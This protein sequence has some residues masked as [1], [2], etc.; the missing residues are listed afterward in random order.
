MARHAIGV[1]C[2]M[3]ATEIYLFVGI[4]WFESLMVGR[5]VHAGG[6]T[7]LVLSFM[8]G[9]GGWV[10][11]AMRRPGPHLWER[12]WPY[13]IISIISL[14]L[15]TVTLGQY[16]SGDAEPSR[17]SSQGVGAQERGFGLGLCQAGS[18]HS[19]PTIA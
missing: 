3:L 5:F 18:S 11:A 8:S 13:V 14:L 9:I 10:M 16:L 1:L 15:F 17:P 2:L 19:Q 7:L 6:W 12:R 4:F